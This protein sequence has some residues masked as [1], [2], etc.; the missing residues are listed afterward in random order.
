MFKGQEN[1]YV[2]TEND[3]VL[4]T[5]KAR[6]ILHQ[7]LEENPAIKRILFEEDD[8]ERVRKRIRK[9]VFSYMENRQAALR[10]YRRE[11]S[12]R[13]EL[14]KLSWRDIAGIRLMDYLDYAGSEFSDPNKSGQ[15]VTSE[16]Y[17]L[18]WLAARFGTGGARK[19]FFRSMLE[20]LR[21]FNGISQR[22]LPS[23][24]KVMEWMDR[25]PSG[26]DPAIV[27]MRQANKR[28]II[29]VIIDLID[30]K[31]KTDPNF[32]FEPGIDRNEKLK[33]VTEWWNYS[34][35]HLRFAAR[36]PEMIN[37]M[38]GHTIDPVTFQLMKKA[39]DAGIPFFVNPHYLSLLNVNS[40]KTFEAADL[41]IRCYV[42]YTPELVREFGHIQA[43]EKEDEIEPG[44]PNAAG[45]IL[46]P[47]HNIHR[48]YPEVA[49]LIPDTMGRA[50]GGLCSVCQRMYDF[51]R[52]ELNFNLDK[53]KP[54]ETWPEK[55]V[56]L[57]HY[58]EEDSHLRD[59][60]VTGG[61]ALMSSD[62]SLERILDAIYEMALRK[63]KANKGRPEGQK[64]AEIIRIRLGTRLPVYLPQRIT[65]SLVQVLTNFKEKAGAIGIRQFVIQ[66]HFETAM[67]VTPE[68]KEA[69]R[70]LLKAGWILTNQQVFTAH[71][72]RRGHTA[73]LRKV[74]NDIGVLPYYTFT[75][76]GHMENYSSYVSTARSV[77]E[78]MEEKVLGVIPVEYFSSLNDFANEGEGII[79]RMAQ[80]RVDLG[81]PFLATDR[82]VLNLPAVGKS[83]T[84][85]VVGITRDGRRI[86]RYD[87]DHTRDHSPIIEQMKHV[88]IVESKSV[89]DYLVQL[90]E[91]GDDQNEYSSIFGYSIGETEPRAVIY[92]Y[93]GY[94]FR[95]T[96]KLTNFQLES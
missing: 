83:L 68:S 79:D 3:H 47:Y 95:L 46:P 1:K 70:K 28:R 34:L 49:I 16:P 39:E 41:P 8:L 74:L 9:W 88:F 10:Y 64:F 38:L 52:G 69:V 12:G 24:K 77:Q 84:Y 17:K 93:P 94:G 63:K 26:L 57:L 5:P 54:R 11:I 73:K 82:N 40:P 35:F 15:V 13:K 86:V 23:R 65:D 72:S 48:R 27:R 81:V 4:I 89:E 75:V 42:F 91:M 19:A 61:D 50:C 62:R 33:K 92:E 31:E 44:K 25:H 53:L 43:W 78:Q 30:G 56:K 59:I 7:I 2:T 22:S 76:K 45:W 87:H 71:A 67:E 18:L 20:V 60:L 36:T 55:L 37:R 14:S 29:E 51:Q 85:R 32:Y 90:E 21:Q 96:D 58:F 80:L 6:K 66:T